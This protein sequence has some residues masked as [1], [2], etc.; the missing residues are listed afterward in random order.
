MIVPI[1]G[2][3][4]YNFEPIQIDDA[5]L[6]IKEKGNIFDENAV[7]TFNTQNQKIGYVSAKNSRNIKVRAKMEQ[8]QIWGK[9]WCISRNQVLVELDF[10]NNTPPNNHFQKKG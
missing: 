10:S 4:Y 3:K 5:V 1:H 8:E 9:V 2:L 6:L 7:A